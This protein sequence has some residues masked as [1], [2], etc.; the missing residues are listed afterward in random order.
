MVDIVEIRLDVSFNH[1]EVFR[2]PVEQ[3]QDDRNRVHGAALFAEAVRVGTEVRLVDRVEDGTEGFLDDPVSES[4]NPERARLS[5]ALGNEHATDRERLV[6]L[7]LQEPDDVGDLRIE[8]LPEGV[9]GGPV[10]PGRRTTGTRQNAFR[11]CFNPRPPVHEAV[12][13]GE[14]VGGSCRAPCMPGSVAFGP[15][16]L[17]SYVLAPAECATNQH[18]PNCPPS[19]CGRFVRPRTTTGAP[20]RAGHWP[21]AGPLRGGEPARFPS[22]QRWHSAC[23]GRS[24]FTPGSARGRAR[25]RGGGC[26]G[27]CR[28]LT[29]SSSLAYL[30]G[31][32]V[33]PPSPDRETG[34]PTFGASNGGFLRSHRGARL[35]GRGG[36]GPSVATLSE[37]LRTCFCFGSSARSP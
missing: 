13:V 1:V 18:C 6:R 33:T 20:P 7:R 15:S 4:R 23:R 16:S 19:P 24:A 12:Q 10:D 21:Q 2:P 9:A 25:H 8:L 36:V 11:G 17:G 14:P 35:A 32:P 26:I 34:S 29:P 27:E 3:G 22:S 37:R 5:I 31:G 28:L 30:N